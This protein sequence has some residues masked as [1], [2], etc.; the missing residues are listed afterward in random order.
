MLI[1]AISVL[2]SP[3]CASKNSSKMEYYRSRG[4]A[5]H[6]N[7]SYPL[8]TSGHS[9]C[10]G[11]GVGRVRV[12]ATCRGHQFGACARDGGNCAPA[13]AIAFEGRYE[14]RVY[15]VVLEAPQQQSRHDAAVLTGG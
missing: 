9:L 2:F 12:P 14:R 15:A 10:V 3:Y 6:T 8:G 13:R 1:L 11:E 4:L 5:T 7:E